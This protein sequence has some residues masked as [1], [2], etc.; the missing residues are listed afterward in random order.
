MWGV[1]LNSIVE[2]DFA[3]L[4]WQR[5]LTPGKS[6]STRAGFAFFVIKYLYSFAGTTVTIRGDRG[7]ENLNIAGL[8]F[9]SVEIAKVS[10]LGIL[11]QT[12]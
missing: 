9:F 8:Q 2:N 5:K 10:C 6:Q 7:T 1:R 12:S 11:L 3:L 4:Q